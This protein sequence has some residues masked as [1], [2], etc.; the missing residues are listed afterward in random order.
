MTTSSFT[1]SITED[2]VFE[3]DEY[4]TLKINSVPSIVDIGDPRQAT[5]TIGDNEG[6]CSQYCSYG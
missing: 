3:V 1:V 2:N 5:I 6:R 4:F